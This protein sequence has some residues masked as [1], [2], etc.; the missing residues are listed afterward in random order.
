M[1]IRSLSHVGLTVSNFD[2]SV[3][4]YYDMF[5]FRLISEQILDEDQ[6]GR[7]YPL[8]RLRNVK[9][10]LG[11][12]RAPKGGVVEI[13]QFS[14]TLPSEHTIWNK[15]GPTHIT[16]DVKNINKWYKNLKKEGVHFFS[17]PQRTHGTDWVFL[18]DPDGNL[19]ELIDLK[20]NY[21]VV[22]ILGGIVGKIMAKGKFNKYYLEN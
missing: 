15:P 8:Y 11:F 7:L 6:V 1:K 17:E 10:H 14:S 12:L 16:F 3:K 9:I 4:W 19:I 22:R 2:K 21:T 18:M 5:G 13:F 20:I